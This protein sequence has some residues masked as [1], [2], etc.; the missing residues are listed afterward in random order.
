MGFIILSLSLLN[1]AS[2]GVGIQRYLRRDE[3]KKRRNEEE[4]KQDIRD[5]KTGLSRDGITSLTD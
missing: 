4:E 2:S 5:V 3:M 1:T